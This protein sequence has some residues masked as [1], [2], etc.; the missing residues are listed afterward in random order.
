MDMKLHFVVLL[1]LVLIISNGV[2]SKKR[3]GKGKVNISV[4]FSRGSGSGGR[5][6]SRSGSKSGSGSSESVETFNPNPCDRVYCFNGGTCV[7]NEYDWSTQCKCR[8]GYTGRLCYR[9]ASV[10]VSVTRTSCTCFVGQ[11]NSCFFVPDSTS[12][13]GDAQDYCGNFGA[14]IWE[15]DNQASSSV[16]TLHVEN[17]PTVYTRVYTMDIKFRNTYCEDIYNE[18]IHFTLAL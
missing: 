9:K 7:V 2:S 17:R 12:S 3:K 13:W 4:Y 10:S 18:T 1:F 15:P 6:G 11:G 16:Q 14:I 5:S 8:Q